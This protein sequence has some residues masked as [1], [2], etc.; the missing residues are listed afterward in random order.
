MKEENK[1]VTNRVPVGKFNC[2]CGNQLVMAY[3]SLSVTC[4]CGE[5]YVN[6]GDE[7]KDDRILV[8]IHSEYYFEMDRKEIEETYKKYGDG[9]DF[10]TWVEEEAQ[11]KASDMDYEFCCDKQVEI[12]RM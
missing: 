10:E 2:K 3:D 1:N 5:H 8:R 11:E 7:S 12:V 6:G 4:R 9:V